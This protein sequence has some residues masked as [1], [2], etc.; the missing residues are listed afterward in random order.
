MSNQ[1]TLLVRLRNVVLTFAV[2][3]IAV[4]VGGMA[5]TDLPQRLGL[6]AAATDPDDDHAGHD[7]GDEPTS[8]DPHAGHDHAIQGDSSENAIELS[9]QARANLGLKVQPVSVGHFS[10]YIEMP[11][12]VTDWPGR[13]HIAITSPLTGVVN[14]IYIARGELIQSDAPL[15]TLRLTHQD[16]VDTQEQFLTSLGQLDV[17][18]REITRLQSVASGAIAGK[19]L[20]TREYERDK[21]LASIR[22]AKQAMLLHGLTEVQVA[23][24]EETRELIREITI[25]APT[26][27]ADR[28]LHHDALHGPGETPRASAN[29]RIA[30]LVQ[31]PPMHPEHIDIDFLVTQLNVSRGESVEAGMKLAQ[32][33]D[34]SEILIEGYAYQRDNAALSRAANAKLPLQ[35]VMESDGE[36]PTVIDDLQIVYIGNE[37]NPLS[38]ALPFFVSLDNQVERSEQVGEHRYVSWRYKPGQ[39]MVL[40]V[41]VENLEDVIVVPKGAVAEEGAER[42][43]FV[44]NGDRFDR[45]PVHVLAG[46]SMNQAIANDGQ[47]WPGQTVAVSGAH[48]LQMAMKNQA[49]G[50]MD[51]HAGHNH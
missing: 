31:P 37:V 43:V 24:I 20:I 25:Y 32:L 2:L 41:P 16:L 42:F 48:Q 26:L 22:A 10:K 5:F 50:G 7:H 28:S 27:H 46:D 21:L 3:S 35:A 39:R 36:D 38:R 1:P 34:Y 29:A 45:I 15:F 6:V 51:P 40:R 17:E 44:E 33:S 9:D 14:A 13:T 30:S 47:L 18:Q 4:V 23:E 11:A 19:T 8:T 49:G 12:A